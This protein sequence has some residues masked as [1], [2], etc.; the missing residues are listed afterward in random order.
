M[1]KSCRNVI[2]VQK[3]PFVT[4]LRYNTTRWLL[5]LV[6]WSCGAIS[7]R[8]RLL[9]YRELPSNRPRWLWY[10]GW[11]HIRATWWE[12][13][14]GWWD[15]PLNRISTPPFSYKWPGLTTIN[16]ISLSG[17]ISLYLKGNDWRFR[18]IW[19]CFS[20]VRVWQCGFV[21]A[22]PSV[23]V[24]PHFLWSTAQNCLCL[25]SFHCWCYQMSTVVTCAPK[26]PLVFRSPNPQ[27][28]I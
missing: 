17:C 14:W 20:V 19:E 27:S 9:V 13:R 10:I 4:S 2:P 16:N 12:T 22:S 5:Y 11:P 6:A 15:R 1:K 25:G 18:W 24:K 21:T 28:V 23:V 3:V 7:T 26:F 8:R